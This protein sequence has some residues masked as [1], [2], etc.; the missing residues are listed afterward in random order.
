V[1]L[2]HASGGGPAAFAE[3]TSIP[4]SVGVLIPEALSLRMLQTT[5]HLANFSLLTKQQ[6]L[7]LIFRDNKHKAAFAEE[8]KRPILLVNQQFARTF[9][10]GDLLDATEPFFWQTRPPPLKKKT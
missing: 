8:L 10:F 1:Y 2:P 4:T 6:N 7:S 9:R 5:K 3:E